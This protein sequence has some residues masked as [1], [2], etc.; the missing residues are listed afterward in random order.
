MKQYNIELFPSVSYVEK[1]LFTKHLSVMIKSGITITESIDTLASQ[2]RSS[3]FKKV[4]TQVLHDIRNGQTLA[5]S[6]QKHPKVFDTFYTSLIEVSEESGTLEENL[7]FLANQLAKDYALRKKIQGALL[8]PGIVITAVTIVGFGMSIFVLPKLVDLFTSMDVKL[9]LTTQILLFFANLMKNHGILVI[10]GFITTLILLRIFV[11]LPK[12]KPLWHAFL[13][14]V[15]IFG[16]FNQSAQLALFSRNLGVMLK[17]GLPI[18]KA[19]DIQYGITSNLV[20]KSYIEKLQ[21]SVNK[22]KSIEDELNS[23]AF[24]LMSPIAIKMIGVGEKTGKLDEVLLYLGDFFED[25]VDN[26][27]KNLSVVLE[28]IILLVIGLI[29]GFVALAILSPIYELTGSIKR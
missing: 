2:T 22:G 29:V 15:P 26:T 12:V 3:L 13:L 1:L 4:L 19:L 28:P 20:F 8:Y 17:S 5:R 27:A 18:K 10:A 6:L 14:A 21:K 25:E 24:S 11:N 7:Q 16:P 23:G 9:P